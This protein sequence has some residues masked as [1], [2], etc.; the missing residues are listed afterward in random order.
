MAT[1]GKWLLIVLMFGLTSVIGSTM[2]HSLRCFVGWWL[3]GGWF[4]KPFFLLFSV[5]KYGVWSIKKYFFGV[6]KY[7]FSVKAVL[8][9]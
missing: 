2:L 5:E 9:I 6:I 1:V 4:A 3:V 8:I 7:F